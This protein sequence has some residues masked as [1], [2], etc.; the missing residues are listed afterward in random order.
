[1]GFF[2]NLGNKVSQAGDK[3]ADSAR[4]SSQISNLET[5]I[6]NY[7]YQIDDAFRQ[8]GLMVYNKT[9]NPDEEQPDYGPLVESID[10]LNSEM[11]AAK[12]EYDWI[13][14]ITHCTH[15][16]A[17]IPIGTKF[18][19]NCGQPVENQQRTCPNCGQIVDPDAKFCL[20]CG[21]RL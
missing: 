20:H 11:N 4:N 14:G 13:R 18:C 10:K 16:G 3:I 12:E 15:C 17:Q 1:M 7:Q 21:A 2:E 6:R 19:P 8:L 5:S 9:K